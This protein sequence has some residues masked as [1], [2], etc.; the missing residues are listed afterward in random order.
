MCTIIEQHVDFPPR[1]PVNAAVIVDQRSLSD[2][3]LLYLAII[4]VCA[5]HQFGFNPSH[6][7]TPTLLLSF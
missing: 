3:D 6:S 7:P 2:P 1:P 5:S 4:T